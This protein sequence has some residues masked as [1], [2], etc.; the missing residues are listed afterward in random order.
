MQGT[1]YHTGPSGPGVRQTWKE[2]DP[3]GE[4]SRNPPDQRPSPE[5]ASKMSCDFSA[6]K[7][8]PSAIQKSHPPIRTLQQDRQTEPKR[9]EMLRD[10]VPFIAVMLVI[11]M[12]W[13]ISGDR[14][15]SV[16]NRTFIAQQTPVL[17]LLAL[18][19]LMVVTTG[20]IDI[21]IGSSLAFWPF[22]ARLGCSGSGMQV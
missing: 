20:S 18:A 21:S 22:A 5:T 8:P 4:F 19:Q 13:A 11:L 2:R 14:F 3:P 15:M 12:F 16:R 7:K 17:M 1:L 9:A 6:L 10:H